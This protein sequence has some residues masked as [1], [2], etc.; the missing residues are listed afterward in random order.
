MPIPAKLN[1]IGVITAEDV[2]A[3]LKLQ[4]VADLQPGD[5]VFMWARKLIHRS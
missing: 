3:M 2:K 1:D 5:C 4:H